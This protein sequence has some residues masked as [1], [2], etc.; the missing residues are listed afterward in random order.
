M[1]AFIGIPL[2]LSVREQLRDLQAQLAAAKADVKWV[3]AENLHVTVKFLGEITD[4]E[5]EAVEE[6]LRRV[7]TH[8]TPFSLGMAGIGAFPSLSSPRVVWVGLR[9]GAERASRLAQAID[10]AGAAIPLRREGRPFAAHV[11]LGRVRSLRGRAR[12]VER[13]RTATWSSPP[14]W[15][16]QAFTLYQSVLSAL[17]PRY[18][19]LAE[20]ALGAH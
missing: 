13:L 6:L 14:P 10:D 19:P 8:E 16:V 3:E 9:E 1:R 7:A 4:A 12:L 15:Q 5:R 11:T 18:T 20:F 2:P 17:G